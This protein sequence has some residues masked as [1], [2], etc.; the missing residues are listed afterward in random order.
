MRRAS[1]AAAVLSLLLLAAASAQEP[2]AAPVLTLTADTALDPAVTYGGLVLAAD[3]IT[4]DGRG[5]RIVGPVQRAAEA[6][7]TVA[8]PNSFTGTGVQATGRSDITLRHLRVQG[9][10]LGLLAEGGMRW[11]IEDCDFSDNFHDPDFGWGDQ[12]EKGGLL[13]RGVLDGK[14]LRNR[15]NRCWD[16]CA[17]VQC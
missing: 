16:A 6:A 10:G 1:P 11:R 12:G 14:L 4:V 3:G 15:A 5:A 7:G 13:L 8:A 9:F 17:L 2:D